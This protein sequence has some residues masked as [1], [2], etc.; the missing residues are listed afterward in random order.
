MLPSQ[1]AELLLSRFPGPVTLLPA[2]GKWIAA[3]GCCTLVAAG[4]SWLALNAGSATQWTQWAW[5]SLFVL[6]ALLA[7]AMVVPGG[8]ALTLDASGFELT[9][10]FTRHRTDWRRASRFKEAGPLVVYDDTERGWNGIWRIIS[11][12]NAL[13]A[14]RTSSLPDT[15]G[16]SPVAL[17]R[18]MERWRERALAQP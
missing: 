10:L 7:A 8:A 12:F 15:F 18:L 1:R 13:F 2:R 11:R 4:L 5:I 16:L 9:I 14:G 6:A 3:F 17:A